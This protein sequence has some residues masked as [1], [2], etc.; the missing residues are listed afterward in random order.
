M[1]R[2][3]EGDPR[4]IVEERPDAVNV[5]NWHWTEKDASKWS[6][7]KLKELFIGQKISSDLALVKITD[8]DKLEGEAAINNRKGKLIFFYEWN[9]TLSWKG[10]LVGASDD[11]EGKIQIPNLSEE[12]DLSE[13]EVLVTLKDSTPEGEVVK[14]FLHHQ[15]CHNVRDKLGEYVRS[16]KEEFS[17]GMILPKKDSEEGKEKDQINCLS[18]GFS[19]KVPDKK[20]VQKWRLKDWPENHFSTVKFVIEQQ[21][22]HTLV[23]ITQTGIPKS[24]LEVTKENWG[25]YYW[26]SI[27]RVFG[28]G[29]F[30]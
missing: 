5:N 21:E 10:R 9:M 3:G 22:D 7:E 20:I 13:V 4:W 1:A 23:K 15:G 11:Y 25:R 30:M 29:Y 2:W 6:Q 14:D 26:D 17:K 16:L 28:W 12:N 27:K 24:E 18:S 19:A 8:V